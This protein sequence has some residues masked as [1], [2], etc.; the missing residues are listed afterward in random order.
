M[1]R[2][3]IRKGTYDYGTLRPQVFAL[4]D[5]FCGDR[6]GRG[7]RVLLKPN[8]LTAAVPDRAVVT[9]PL[10]VKAAAEYVLKKG[11]RP[12]VSDSPG[13]GSF[14]RI[15]AESGLREALK[16]LDVDCRPFKTS[17]QVKVGEPFKTIEIA[18]DAVRAEVVINLPKMKT[19]SQMLLT[20]GVKNLFGCVVGL[21]KPEWHFRTGVDREMFARLLLAVCRAVNPAV[22]LID[23]IL[24]MEGQGPGKSGTPRELGLLIAGR[25][26]AAVDMTACRVAGVDPDRVLTNVVARQAG[27]VPETVD[28]RGDRVQASRPFDLPLMTPLVFGPKGLHRFMRSYLVQRPVCAEALCRLCGECWRYC[29]AQAI[30]HGKKGIRFDYDACI[31]CYCCIEV[32]PEGALRAKEPLPGKLVRRVFGGER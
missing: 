26:P 3:F 5:E 1:S 20:L 4:L 2:V 12:Q 21:R 27:L 23:G 7:S 18:E 14:D 29:P 6:I 22:T 15:L 16:G 31:R 8:L 25:D 19:H 17:V 9:H 28:L 24:A 11:G 13:T 30:S 10:V 32:C